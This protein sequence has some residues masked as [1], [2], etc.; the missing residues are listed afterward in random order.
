VKRRFGLSGISDDDGTIVCCF[1]RKK[2]RKDWRISADVMGGRKKG[3]RDIGKQR[4]QEIGSVLAERHV[5]TSKK[6]DG[7]RPSADRLDGLMNDPAIP[8]YS[9]EPKLREVFQ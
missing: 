6:N 5:Q 3:I 9:G 1:S 8:H 2:S 7:G 4:R